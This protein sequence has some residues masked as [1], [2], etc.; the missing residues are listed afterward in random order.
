MK[1]GV[2]MLRGMKLLS[3]LFL[4]VLLCS[5]A[6]VTVKKVTAGDVNTSGVKYYRPYPYLLVTA[7][8]EYKII[9][10]PKMDEEYS[11]SSK[12][13]FGSAGATCKLENGWNL[14]EYSDKLDS[15]VPETIN[16]VSGLLK[17]AAAA[18]KEITE[19]KGLAPG[20]YRFDF[21][22][23]TGFVTGVK[24]ILKF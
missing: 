24:E 11:I 4:S 18:T 15:K 14:T 5:C 13:G 21:D 1:R 10:L 12:P 20:L 2:V 8:S 9:Y 6:G 16:A 19:F 3:V 17:E 23:Q 7:Q 22:K